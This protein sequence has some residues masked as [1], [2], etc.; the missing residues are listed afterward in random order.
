MV[1]LLTNLD[2]IFLFQSSFQDQH[3]LYYQHKHCHEL[4]TT[5]SLTTL[6]VSLGA[7]KFQAIYISVDEGCSWKTHL[8]TSLQAG[9]HKNKPNKEARKKGY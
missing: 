5:P 4:A 2:I 7:R 9:V 6:I 3:V 8:K 1:I